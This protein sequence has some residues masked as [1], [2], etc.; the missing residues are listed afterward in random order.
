MQTPT[1]AD[2]TRSTMLEKGKFGKADIFR[3]EMPDGIWIVKDFAAHTLPER[4]LGCLMISREWRAYRLL[5]GVPGIAPAAV[6]IDS[7]SLATAR[8]EGQ[9]LTVLKDRPDQARE[10]L[11]ALRDRVESFHALG[12]AHLDLRGTGNVRIDAA[13]NVVLLDLASAAFWDPAKKPGRRVNLYRAIDRSA[14]LKWK[15]RLLPD[16]MTP[17]EQQRLALHRRVRRY[18]VFNPRHRRVAPASF[19]DRDSDS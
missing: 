9:P 17:E 7:V 19:R 13:G 2:I 12:M 6:R 11:Q 8:V 14:C 10:A 1:R 5:Q 15:A 16:E 4:W 18:W 3:V